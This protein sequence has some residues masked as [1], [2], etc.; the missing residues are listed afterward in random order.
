[1]MVGLLNNVTPGEEQAW[2]QY[3]YPQFRDF[4][5]HVSNTIELIEYR[6]TEG[7]L[8][9]SIY[10][11]EAYILT[12]ST[13]G[14]YE[15]ASWISELS[16]FIKQVY[17]KGDTKLVGICFGHQILAQ[18]LGGNVEKAGKGWGLGRREF[19]LVNTPP[20][21]MTPLPEEHA[22]YYAHQDQVVTLPE[23]ATL[24]ATDSF[25]LNGIFEL[26][27]RVLG[28][29]GHPEFSDAVAIDTIDLVKEQAPQNVCR[30]ALESLKQGNA[31]GRIVA[32]WIVN[33]L[34]E[35][36]QARA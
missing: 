34:K 19:K 22:L 11:C 8:P 16:A 3:E 4:L 7:Q 18:A 12:G 26:N 33:F 29:Q 24:L 6:V 10:D 25:C 9:S 17:A 28:I 30:N 32:Q 36:A 23:N 31:D 14:A 21:W 1:M 5:D 27:D 13:C 2:G 20:G 15:P 35:P